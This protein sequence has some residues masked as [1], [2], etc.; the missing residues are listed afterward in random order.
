MLQLPWV[1]VLQH[2]GYPVA[3]GFGWT[4]ERVSAEIAQVRRR[5]GLHD[6]LASEVQPWADASELQP[7]VALAEEYHGSIH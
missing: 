6:Q 4:T 1:L 5:V 2:C 7:Q 3:K